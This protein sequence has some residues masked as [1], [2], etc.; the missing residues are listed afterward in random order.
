MTAETTN[1]DAQPRRRVGLRTRINR[2][3]AKPGFQKWAARF[4]L[5]RG[6]ARREGEDLFE[7][8]QGFVKSQVLFALVELRIPHRLMDGP[9]TAGALAQGSGVPVHRMTQLLQAGAAM[10]LLTRRR[11][12]RF[13]IA[14][15]GAAMLG[16]PGLEQMIRHHDVLYRDLADPVALL[17]GETQTEL[18]DFWPYVFGAQGAVDPAITD[19]YSDLMAD[20]QG[21]VADDTL[22]AVSLKDVTHLMDV[23]GGTGA[24]VRAAARAWPGLALTLVDLP[25]VTETARAK[26]AGAGLADRV[27]ITGASFRDDPLPRGA[28]AISLVRVLYDHEDDTVRALLAK[29]HDTLPPGGRLIVSEPMSGGARPESSGDVYFAFYCMAMRTGTVRSQARIAELCRDAGFEGVQMPRAARPFV[30][31]V[32]AAR[33]PAKP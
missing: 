7:I 26:M 20:S 18:A 9:M 1:P 32:V 30:T 33:K 10:G 12:G 5:T 17:R 21:L 8:V 6:I 16:V 25:V 22:R 14:R 3:A 28:D 2:I 11:D 4:P 13:G 23:G 19:T 15:K 29:V 31:S 27:T 24:F